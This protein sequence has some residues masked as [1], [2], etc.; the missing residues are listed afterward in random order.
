MKFLWPTVY[1]WFLLHPE[2]Y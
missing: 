1:T 2:L